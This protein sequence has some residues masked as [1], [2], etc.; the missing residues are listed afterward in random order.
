[1]VA[2]FLAVH[3]VCSVYFA[4][5]AQLVIQS[6]VTKLNGHQGLQ[7]LG[8]QQFAVVRVVLK[9][10]AFAHAKVLDLSNLVV[11]L[12]SLQTT[13]E[14]DL[15]SNLFKALILQTNILLV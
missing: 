5:D 2:V 3:D 6:D 7:V 15:K 12:F 8:L 1:M 11:I 14:V 13:V 10:K 9:R 4:L